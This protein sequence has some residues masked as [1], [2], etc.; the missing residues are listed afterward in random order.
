MIVRICE[1]LVVAF[2]PFPLSP[3]F[4]AGSGWSRSLLLN[5]DLELYWAGL[6]SPA[7]TSLDRKEGPSW[8]LRS[9]KKLLEGLGEM[10]VQWNACAGRTRF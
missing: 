10:C 5:L 1:E 6:V 7:F 9:A 2:F 4:P 3:F 8:G